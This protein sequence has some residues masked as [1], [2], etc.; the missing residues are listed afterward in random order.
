MRIHSFYLSYFLL[1]FSTSL[2]VDTF[3]QM[4][5]VNT[6]HEDRDR[7]YLLYLPTGFTN[8]SS[9]DLV[10]GFHG[11]GGTASGLEREVTGNFNQFAD[12]IRQRR[13]LHFTTESYCDSIMKML[14]IFNNNTNI[15]DNDFENEKQEEI[16]NTKKS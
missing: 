4:F 11:Y 2:S 10:I 3:A 6:E 15:T 9:I 16:D 8:Q 7:H 12:I 13:T 14:N 5:R 1:I